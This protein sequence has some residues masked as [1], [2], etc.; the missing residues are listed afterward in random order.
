MK[1]RKLLVKDGIRALEQVLDS[2]PDEYA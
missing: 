2:G 1:K